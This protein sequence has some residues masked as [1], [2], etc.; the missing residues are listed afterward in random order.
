MPIGPLPGLLEVMEQALELLC[1]SSCRKANEAVVKTRFKYTN[2][3]GALGIYLRLIWSD[4]A[5]L[6][7]VYHVYR[8]PLST[9]KTKTDG[10]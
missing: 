3:I 4:S 7:C 1:S 8:E 5:G 9:M 10:V 2:L 6:L